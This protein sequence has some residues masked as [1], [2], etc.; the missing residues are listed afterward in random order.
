VILVPARGHDALHEA[1]SVLSHGAA[2]VACAFPVAVCDFGDDFAALFHGFEDGANIEL[3]AEG[4]F[5]TD[6]DV[7]EIDEDSN[8]Q[9]LIG[10]FFQ[11][12]VVS[13]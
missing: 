11:W 10:H 2:V 5:Y 4:G 3:A 7:V 9:S 8:L 6:L 13:G 1:Y 12:S